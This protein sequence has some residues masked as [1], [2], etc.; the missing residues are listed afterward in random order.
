M[1]ATEMSKL[2]L[3][4]HNSGM[5]SAFSL[6]FGGRLCIYKGANY[7]HS[8]LLTPSDH[9]R[10]GGIKLFPILVL[11]IVVGSSWFLGIH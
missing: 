1:M 4:L 7:V 2:Q 6:L 11:N 3:S 5:E 8:I 9:I 10:C